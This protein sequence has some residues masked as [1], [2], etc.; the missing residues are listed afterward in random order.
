[1]RICLPISRPN[2]T[3]EGGWDRIKRMGDTKDQVR[4]RDQDHR[5][6]A[7]GEKEVVGTVDLM[8]R[9]YISDHIS[10]EELTV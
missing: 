9:R 5:R 7:T 8:H 10:G 4:G 6:L 2:D 3:V 1:M